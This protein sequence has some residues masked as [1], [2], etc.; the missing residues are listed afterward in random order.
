MF[1]KWFKR[2]KLRRKILRFYKASYPHYTTYQDMCKAVGLRQGRETV[3]ELML[4]IRK[5]KLL[6]RP[7]TEVVPLIERG[8][9]DYCYNPDWRL[10]QRI[11]K[12]LS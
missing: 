11:M 10:C 9:A 6:P 5:Q 1:K 4:L 8:P 7:A 3:S 2:R 12:G